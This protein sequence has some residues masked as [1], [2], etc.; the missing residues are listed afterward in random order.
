MEHLAWDLVVCISTYQICFS[1]DGLL[2]SQHLTH[3]LRMRRVSAFR[4][5]FPGENLCHLPWGRVS[6][7]SSGQTG[8]TQVKVRLAWSTSITE[9]HPIFLCLCNIFGE[10]FFPLSVLYVHWHSGVMTLP[11]L[12]FI[13]VL[14]PHSFW[15]D[16]KC[17]RVLHFGATV[18]WFVEITCSFRD[19]HLLTG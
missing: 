13:C 2:W 12:S 17:Y 15:R 3:M 18:V 10:S 1:F 8:V 4:R 9:Q 16:L 14:S 7:N 6:I 11:H 5:D 19:F